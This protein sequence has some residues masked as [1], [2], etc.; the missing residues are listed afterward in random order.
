M[1][2]TTNAY[3]FEGKVGNF[4]QRLSHQ[5]AGQGDHTFLM[6][7]NAEGAVQILHFECP[8]ESWH[9]L[10]DKL[11]KADMSYL[12]Y[13]PFDAPEYTWLSWSRIECPA[14]ERLIGGHFEEADFVKERHGMSRAPDLQPP[15]QFPASWGVMF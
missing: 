12:F 6:V 13:D 9:T 4:A 10:T 2:H 3:P 7:L 11:N 15:S 1:P 5:L 8:D 14:M